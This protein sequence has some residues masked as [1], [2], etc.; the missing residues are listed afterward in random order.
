V[1]TGGAPIPEMGPPYV[2]TDLE[3]WKRRAPDG[4]GQR[5]D[6]V[7]LATGA[8]QTSGWRAG[9]WV[10]GNTELALGTAIATFGPDGRYGNR[11]DGTSHAAIY[12]GQGPEGLRILD[13]YTGADGIVRKQ[14]RILRWEGGNPSSQ[15]VDEGKNYRVIR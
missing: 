4:R 12:L 5:V 13:Q 9:D 6:L 14:G 15:S 11:T 2:A 1:A 8:P 3:H 10:R 7:K